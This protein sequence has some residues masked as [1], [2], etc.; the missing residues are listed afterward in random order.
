MWVVN[1][2]DPDGFILD[3]KAQ[4]MCRRKLLIL[5]GSKSLNHLQYLANWAAAFLSPSEAAFC[6][7]VH[8]FIVWPSE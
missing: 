8:A 5:N 6:Q 3:L 1:F 7:S 2:R 4:Q